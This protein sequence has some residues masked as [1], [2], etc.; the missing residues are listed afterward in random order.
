LAQSRFLPYFVLLV[1][2]FVAATSSILVRLAQDSGA[3]AP[4]MVIAAWRLVVASALIT[5]LAWRNNRS[6][7]GRLRRK[8]LGWAVAAGVLLAIH[9]AT[10]ITSL[11]YT[12]VASSA[13]LVTTNPLWVALGIYFIFGEKLSRNT[14]LGLIAGFTGSLL[15][16]FSDG[17]L[18][19]IDSHGVQFYW[20]NLLA[21]A[22]KADTALYGDFL[23]LVGA[24]TV[25]AYLLVGRNLRRRISNTAYVWLV[26]SAAM[27]AMLGVVLFSHQAMVGYRWPIYLWLLLLGLGPQLMGHTA[28]N[29]ALAHLSATLVALTVLGE[30]IGS[31]ILA[32]FVFGE[33]FA[34]VQL[35]GLVLLL[36][37]ISLGVLGEQQQPA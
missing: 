14:G 4:S 22:G 12:S 35:T 21:P 1:G 16:A 31:S 3:G 2:V 26:Y 13:A 11:E 17:G 36:I 32:Y 28:Y 10:W 33:T 20:G 18:L 15:I 37:G 23:A 19:S 24:I 29:W 25:A 27:V 30:P 5:P 8:D 9:L 6:E 7:V 34:P